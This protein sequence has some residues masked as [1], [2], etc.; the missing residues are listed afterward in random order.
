MIVYFPKG[1][2]NISG[3][4]K[5]GLKHGDWMYFNENAENVKKEE[6]KNGFLV[7]KT[8]YQYEDGKSEKQEVE[9]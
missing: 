2:V 6:F 9:E 5:N 3:S 7:S 1:G 4:Y 8:L